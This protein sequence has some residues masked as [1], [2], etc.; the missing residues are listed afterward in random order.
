[1]ERP[2]GST[3]IR[4]A[5][6]EKIQPKSFASEKIRTSRRRKLEMRSAESL[7]PSSAS[8]IATNAMN[9]MSIAAT[10]SASFRPSVVPAVAASM[11]FT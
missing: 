4:N 3:P 5:A 2:C 9:T 7:L 1:M 10:F 6:G 8:N 11:P